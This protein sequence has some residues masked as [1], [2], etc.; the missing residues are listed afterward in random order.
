[1]R[2]A[3]R[4]WYST[5]YP[6]GNFPIAIAFDGTNIWVANYGSNNVTVLNAFTG[7]PASNINGGNPINV[8]INPRDIVFDGTNIWVTNY[9][10]KSVTALK[11]S[12]GSLVGTYEVG[13]HP[14]GVAFD[15][16]NIWVTNGRSNSV[17][18]LKR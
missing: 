4:Q 10:S 8:G 1:M 11:A 17:S 6:V 18:K 12:D 16:A 15:G 14:W 7:Q 2:A 9:G 5:S 3:L 13:N